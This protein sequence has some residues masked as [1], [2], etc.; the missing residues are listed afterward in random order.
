LGKI[1]K[2]SQSNT[3]GPVKKK[4]EREREA[5]FFWGTV[6]LLCLEGGRQTTWII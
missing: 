5:M 1:N 4:T 6:G 2:T 3:H